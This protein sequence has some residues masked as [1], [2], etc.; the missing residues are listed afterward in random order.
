MPCPTHMRPVCLGA[1][2]VFCPE[3]EK[4]PSGPRA[5]I[6]VDL[7][8]RKRGYVTP[9]KVQ[10]LPG[11]GLLRVPASSPGRQGSRVRAGRRH[12]P[13]NAKCWSPQRS[14]RAASSP[15]SQGPRAWASNRQGSPRPTL[16]PGNR[17][18]TPAPWGC[19]HPLPPR[20]V[21]APRPQLLRLRGCHAAARPRTT[22]RPASLPHPAPVPRM[23]PLPLRPHASADT[24]RQLA[25]ACAPPHRRLRGGRAAARMRPTS[26]T[27]AHPR[28][29]PASLA[30]R[31]RVSPYVAFTVRS[32]SRSTPK[33]PPSVPASHAQQPLPASLAPRHCV[34]GLILASYVS[35][36]T[37]CPSTGT[38]T[39]HN[40]PFDR[41]VTT[42]TRSLCINI[43][44]VRPLPVCASSPARSPPV[45]SYGG[46]APARP[47]LALSR[48]LHPLRPP[49]AHWQKPWSISPS[50]ERSCC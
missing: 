6:G 39:P 17:A 46:I 32:V 47:T 9:T 40:V 44:P 30:A 23:R 12:D 48:S 4:V 11:A 29:R 45:V 36:T 20:R 16:R 49:A 1:C 41:N 25:A 22:P 5:L 7:L 38:S 37:S 26:R 24:A 10:N 35:I 18:S 28:S 2:I 3:T 31:H 43:S 13:L 42:N 33:Q 15:G 34:F 21:R 14:E 50:R 8:A 27:A 19:L